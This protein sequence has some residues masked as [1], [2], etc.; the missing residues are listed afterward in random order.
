MLG[1]ARH[2]DDV[3]EEDQEGDQDAERD[4]NAVLGAGIDGLN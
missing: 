3:G 2:Q 4:W 1:T